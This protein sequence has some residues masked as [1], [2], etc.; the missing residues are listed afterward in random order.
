[1]RR[2]QDAIELGL[3]GVEGGEVPGFKS[4]ERERAR[5]EQEGASA[6]N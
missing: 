4:A 3:I 1:M 2:E 5:Q 6:A